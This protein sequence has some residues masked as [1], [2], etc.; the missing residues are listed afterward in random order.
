MT[1]FRALSF[2][3]SLL[4][5]APLAIAQNP[6]PPPDAPGQ[7]FHGE[8]RGM[9]PG[10]G[11]GMGIL[12]PGA[13]W[14]NPSIISTLSLSADQQK[15]M[16]DIFLQSKIQL[17]H[18]KASLEEEQVKLEPLLNANPPD[19]GKTLAQISRIADLRADLEKADAK[20]LLGLRGILTAD[21]WTKLQAQRQMRRPDSPDGFRGRRAPD[22]PGGPGASHGP[23]GTDGPPPGADFGPA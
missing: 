19:Q 23:P 1:L 10:M 20:M 13:W 6:G 9:G 18:M 21:Q 3:C 15:R 12:P 5:A 11:P 2:A 17:I 22:G 7:M 16:D 8:G 4:F 14:K